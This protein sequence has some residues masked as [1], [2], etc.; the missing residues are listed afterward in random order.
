MV[1]ARQ[2]QPQEDAKLLKCVLPADPGFCRGYAQRYFYDSQN[3]VCKT[4][5]WGGCLG[6]ANN[7]VSEQDCMSAC[8]Q[9]V[10]PVAFGAGKGARLIG[11]RVQG[12]EL[13]PNQ[14][15]DSHKDLL[16]SEKESVECHFGNLTLNLG[17]IVLSDDPCEECI[18]STPPEMSCTQKTCPSPPEGAV[19]KMEYVSGQCCPSFS[20][21]SANPPFIDVCTGVECKENEHCKVESQETDDGSWAPPKGVCVEVNC[22]QETCPPPLKLNNAVCRSRIIPGQCCP[23]Y[24][25]V[26]ANPPFIDVC[27]GVDCKEN[28]R[29][30]VESQETADGSWAPPKGVCVEKSDADDCEGP[31]CLID[32]G[33][34]DNLFKEK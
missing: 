21:V 14:L 15:A 17:D 28:E 32:G 10:Q 5:V 25:C 8:H 27:A 19:C 13:S 20:C 6:N 22:A 11:A 9:Q 26:S 18:C 29:C 23:S 4:F 2:P 12:M 24:E 16:H 34:L 3:K 1:E 7:F 31:E 33:V 30:K